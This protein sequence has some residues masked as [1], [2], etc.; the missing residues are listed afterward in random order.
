M[1]ALV[2]LQYSYVDVNWTALLGTGGIYSVSCESDY[3]LL[4]LVAMCH[5]VDDGM[6]ISASTKIKLL[7]GAD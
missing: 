5:E 6:L 1:S 2:R 3:L 4:L 7:Y